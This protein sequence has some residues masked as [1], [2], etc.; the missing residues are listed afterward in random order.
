MHE[1][2][3]VWLSVAAAAVAALC[4]VAAGLMLMTVVYLALGA[5]VLG[6]AVGRVV[7]FILPRNGK[8][9]TQSKGSP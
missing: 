4:G 1:R 2:L 5:L 8:S 7:G 6:L 3:T 9:Q